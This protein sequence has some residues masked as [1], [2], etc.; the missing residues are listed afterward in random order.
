M[1]S[2]KRAKQAVAAARQE[3]HTP[4]MLIVWRRPNAV[5]VNMQCVVVCVSVCVAAAMTPP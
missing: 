5:D 3:L 1:H 4:R 2:C